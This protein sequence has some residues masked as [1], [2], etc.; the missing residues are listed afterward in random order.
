MNNKI[1]VADQDNYNSIIY[2]FILLGGDNYNRLVLDGNVSLG[3][4]QT[5]S[6]G[7]YVQFA[8]FGSR[9]LTSL[10][11]GGWGFY[12]KLDPARNMNIGINCTYFLG[13]ER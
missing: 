2:E 3:F 11:K 1:L 8:I 4:S 10:S 6:N 12:E 9:N 7:D 13:Y 5:L